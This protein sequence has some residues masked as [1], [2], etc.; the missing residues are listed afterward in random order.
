M[1]SHHK[2]QC[3]QRDS[4]YTLKGLR[5]GQPHREISHKGLVVSPFELQQTSY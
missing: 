2:D 3:I 5:S 4:K 1:R